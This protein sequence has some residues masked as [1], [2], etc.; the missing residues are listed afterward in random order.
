MGCAEPFCA[1]CLVD[2][3]GQKYCGAC[4]V[5]ALPKGEHVLEEATEPS[6]EASEALKYAIVGMFC[7][8]FILGP[9]AISKALKARNSIDANPRM[10]GS[11]KAIAAIVIGSVA[12]V[13][14][15]LGLLVR[16]AHLSPR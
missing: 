15:G 2:L 12:L 7:F 3:Q 9:V 13:L 8:G 10:T 1:N 5:M 4:K 14:S 11:G 6:P 16:M